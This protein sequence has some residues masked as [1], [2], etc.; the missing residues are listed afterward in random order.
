MDQIYDR[1][2]KALDNAVSAFNSSKDITQIMRTEEDSL[3]TYKL[4]LSK[5]SFHINID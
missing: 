4:L 2:V 1:A 5:K 3:S